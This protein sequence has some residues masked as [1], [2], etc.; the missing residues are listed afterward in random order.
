MVNENLCERES[1]SDADKQRDPAKRTRETRVVNA[2]S[3]VLAAAGSIGARLYPFLVLYDG[4]VR[5]PGA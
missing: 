4:C 2:A 1:D 3:R 5:V